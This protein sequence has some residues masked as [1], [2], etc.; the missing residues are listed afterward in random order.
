MRFFAFLIGFVVFIDTLS[1]GNYV[2]A[3][4]FLSE[5]EKTS[6]RD[7]I[8]SE[9][10][11]INNL[12][13]K[14]NLIMTKD[15]GEPPRQ[16]IY[17]WAMSGEKQYRKRYFSSPVGEPRNERF[18]LAVWDGQ[19]LK[20]YDSLINNG[21]IRNKY[22]SKDPRQPKTSC[23]YTRQLGSLDEGLISEILTKTPLGDW[24]AEWVDN[25]TK[26]VFRY[27]MPG[28]EREWTF[29]LE[30]SC[31]I[32]K[33][34]SIIKS[35]DGKIINADLKVTVSESQEVKPGIWL[36]TKS[37]T[38]AAYY[39][40]DKTLIRDND[41]IVEEIKANE[42]EIEELFHFEFPEGAQYYDYVIGQT[43]MMKPNKSLFQK[44]RWFWF[45]LLIASLFVVVALHQGFASRRRKNSQ[46]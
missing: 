12:Y 37:H 7:R 35:F 36:P 32:T 4:N 14:F 2:Y 42:P 23:P 31:I 18:G 28:Y 21:S 45:A 8:V 9:Q 34:V 19:F 5:E 26:V 46:K 44:F 38:H 11:K 20:A 3:G 1:I 13:V 24:N 10:L 41:I 33:F 30:K 17:E 27:K 39:F 29:D 6:I 43:I 22:D 40:P 16:Q 25:E 15:N